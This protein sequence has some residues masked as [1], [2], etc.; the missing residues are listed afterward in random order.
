[1]PEDVTQWSV[2]CVHEPV[3]SLCPSGVDHSSVAAIPGKKAPEVEFAV[4]DYSALL[5]RYT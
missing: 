5:A 2:M 1:M 3:A 4:L